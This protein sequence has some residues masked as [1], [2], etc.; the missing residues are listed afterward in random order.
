MAIID[1]QKHTP[2][3]GEHYFLDCNVLMYVFYLNGNYACD[4]VETYSSLISR[5]IYSGAEIY[6]TDL[7]ISEFINTYIQ[8]EFHRL[9]A[10]NK[11]SH[12]KEYFKK[13]FKNTVEYSDI[14]K[15]LKCI[16]QRQLFTISV[17]ID[18]KFSEIM[19]ETIFDNPQTFD[20]ND[21]YYGLSLGKEEIYI[22]SNDADF[23]NV[24]QCDIV[25]KNH[26]LLE[27]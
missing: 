8:L 13:V 4:L 3:K 23:S 12:S 10:L 2:K 5:I 16:L 7:L 22:V 6:V 15:E 19:L 21:R 18:V 1:I 27:I 17:R 24:S 20:F 14:L 9:A 11:W 25:T 26:S